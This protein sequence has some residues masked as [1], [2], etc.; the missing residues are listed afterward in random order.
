VVA[1]GTQAGTAAEQWQQ[2]V[3]PHWSHLKPAGQGVGAVGLQPG[4]QVKSR[5][6]LTQALIR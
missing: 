1:V 6:V 2:G 4:A 3:A 5:S